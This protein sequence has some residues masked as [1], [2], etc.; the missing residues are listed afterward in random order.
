[1]SFPFCLKNA[2][3]PQPTGIPSTCFYKQTST[4]NVWF[5]VLGEEIPNQGDS[6]I[7]SLFNKQYDHYEDGSVIPV[8]QR[9]DALD[10]INIVRIPPTTKVELYSD[11]FCSPGNL[12]A[13]LGGEYIK[14]HD[15]PGFDGY[16]EVTLSGPG[17]TQVGCV[18]LT[19]Y[20]SWDSFVNSC[21]NGTTVQN[22]CQQYA[23]GDGS[24]TEGG[25]GGETGGDDDLVPTS[26]RGWLY[27]FIIGA[28]VLVAVIVIVCLVSRQRNIDKAKR[29][30]SVPSVPVGT[31]PL[32]NPDDP[33]SPQNTPPEL[34]QEPQ[35]L[36]ESEYTYAT[37]SSAIYEGPAPEVPPRPRA[38]PSR[39][40]PKPSRS[41]RGEVTIN[42][43]EFNDVRY[44]DVPIS[45][46]TGSVRSQASF[47]D[48]F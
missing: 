33:R 10:D 47:I 18:K 5:G 39:S 21:E 29:V 26:N 15:S 9:P 14:Y 25:G 1:M 8:G 13:T 31:A 37:P 41:P 12:M 6:I 44:P 16:G 36:E 34:I 32:W 4:G 48:S 42:T 3:Y 27:A 11:E 38:R 23:S 17:A 40:P 19:Q 7:I 20:D 35:S 45:S 2:Q 46:S 28:L 30:P 24:G 22:I 43:P